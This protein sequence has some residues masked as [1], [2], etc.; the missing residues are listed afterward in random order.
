MSGSSS[1]ANRSSRSAASL[2]A[3]RRFTREQQPARAPV[4]HC[5]LCGEPVPAEH[6]HLLDT[7]SQ[8]LVCAC[9]A[10]GLLFGPGALGGKFRIVPDRYLALPDFQMTDA[11]WDEL[12]IPVN[13]AFIFR[14]AD[15]RAAKAYYPGPAGATE[16]LLDLEGWATLTA[17]NPILCDLEPDVEALLINHVGAAREHYIVPIDAGYQLV[18]LIRSR[19]RGLSG[20]E[21]VWKAIGEYFAALRAKCR[22][23]P[24]GPDAEPEL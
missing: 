12:A 10:C 9:R 6:Q 3:L 11:Q 15:E 4:E 16:S 18:G 14:G 22:P 21:E 2:G 1:S 5:E 17:A 23:A 7:S 24:G 13:M 19:W 8:T 20:G